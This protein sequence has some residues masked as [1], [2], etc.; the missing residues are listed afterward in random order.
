MTGLPLARASAPPCCKASAAF[1]VKRSGLIIVPVWFATSM[2]IEGC[3]YDRSSRQNER[4]DNE[5]AA[6]RTCPTAL[7]RPP[8]PLIALFHHH[9]FPREPFSVHNQ[10]IDVNARRRRLAGVPDVPVPVRAIGAAHSARAAQLE[11]VDHLARALQNGHRNR[12]E[13][14]RVGKECRSRWS[15]Y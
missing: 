13:E 9:H 12:S 6:E 5:R 4:K 15:P 7:H 2:P 1:T 14:R 8:P 10:L 3:R 11:V